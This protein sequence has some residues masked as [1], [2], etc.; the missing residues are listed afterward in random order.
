MK[1]AE[2]FTAAVCRAEGGCGAVEE[3]VVEPLRA[4]VRRS[5]FGVLVSTGCL[6]RHL[7]CPHHEG[8]RVPRP[9]IRVVVQPCARDRT[10]FGPAITFGPLTV[11]SRAEDLATW[12]T[13]GL[14]RGCRP[15]RHLLAVR[16]SS[17][18]PVPGP[19]GG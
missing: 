4:A 6:A 8:N 7:S 11:V 15:P 16:P 18:R 13:N 5:V 10:P 1:S 17:R 9:G 14:S 2:G 3:S 19:P 12:L